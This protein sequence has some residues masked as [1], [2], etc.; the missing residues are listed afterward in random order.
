MSWIKRRPMDNG[1]QCEISPLPTFDTTGRCYRAGSY[2]KS[3][4]SGGHWAP[5]YAYEEQGTGR[6]IF[7][8]P[9]SYSAQGS[10]L[11]HCHLDSGKGYGAMQKG[12]EQGTYYLM[13]TREDGQ[14][15]YYVSLKKPAPAAEAEPSA[16][17]STQ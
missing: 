16:S 2:L 11:A 9:V 3:D 7:S 13:G 6:L 15:Q 5:L 17:A 14:G 8:V 10:S 12:K 1:Y 4:M